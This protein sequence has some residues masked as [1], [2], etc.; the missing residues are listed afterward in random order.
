MN[1]KET[2]RH[3]LIK[4]ESDE[5]SIADLKRDGKTTWEGV[6]NFEARNFMRDKMQPGDLAFFYHSNSKPS[7]IAGL[8][9]VVQVG[10]PDP[11]QF[12]KKS[13]YYDP[14]SPKDDPR[15]RMIEVEFVEQFKEVLSLDRLKEEKALAKMWLLQK[16]QR[17]SVQPVAEAHFAHILK[18]AR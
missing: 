16:G 17:L 2:G 10:I 8:A 4:S 6:R 5:Y 1:P 7:G 3:W 15:W 18:M 13:D 9:R 11:T 12:K 14:T